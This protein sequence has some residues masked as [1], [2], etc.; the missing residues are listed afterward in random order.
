MTAYPMKELLSDKS[1]A[2]LYWWLLG[3]CARHPDSLTDKEWGRVRLINK[4]S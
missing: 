1:Q 4:P 3:W 2:R